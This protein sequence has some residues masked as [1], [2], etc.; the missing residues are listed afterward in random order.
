MEADDEDDPTRSPG[1]RLPPTQTLCMSLMS[2]HA[3]AAQILN[4]LND[5]TIRL[6]QLLWQL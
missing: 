1:A 3:L 2:D 4:A 6:L 5:T